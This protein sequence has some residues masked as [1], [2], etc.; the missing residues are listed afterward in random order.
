MAV[1]E[2]REGYALQKSAGNYGAAIVEELNG[3]GIVRDD[4]LAEGGK[5]LRA[6]AYS[7]GIQDLTVGLG[8]E[9]LW[10]HPCFPD[11][12]DTKLGDPAFFALV[13]V[14][15]VGALGAKLL[16]HC[17]L[18]IYTNPTKLQVPFAYAV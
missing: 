7:G 17:S 13:D 6:Q 10:E 8:G 4:G 9:L 3:S 18:P 11:A 12:V 15:A 5:S 16:P 14:E 2:G 1:A